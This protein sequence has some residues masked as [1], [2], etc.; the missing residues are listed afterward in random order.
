METKKSNRA[1]LEKKRSVFFQIGLLIAL[2]TALLAF[3]WQ[4]SVRISDVNWE[5]LTND[6]DVIDIVRTFQEPPPTLPPPPP[7]PGFELE[8]VDND[9]FFDVSEINFNIETGYNILPKDFAHAIPDEEPEP[10]IFDIFGVE[11]QALFD[12]KQ[13][14][15]GLRDYTGKNLHYPQLALNNGISGKVFVQFVVDQKGNVVDVKI[16]R[17][18]DPLLNNEAVRIIQSTSGRWTPAMQ[19]GNPVKVRYSFPIYFKLQ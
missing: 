15:D 13:A 2:S 11:V 8:I 18:A 10:D 16:L 17:G 6:I 7:Q 9:V 5:P 19:R 1:N 12:G 4:V 3:E 14:E